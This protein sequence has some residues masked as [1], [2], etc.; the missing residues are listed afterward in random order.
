M[1]KKARILDKL[2]ARLHTTSVRVEESPTSVRRGAG[3]DPAVNKKSTTDEKSVESKA[4]E[5]EAS[6][7]KKPDAVATR[8]ADVQAHR[9][10]SPKEEAS[11][12]MKDGFQELGSLLRGMQSRID[13][14]GEQI[15]R[16]M[17]S[18][19]QLPQ[20]GQQ[21][22]ETLRRLADRFDRQSEQNAVIARSLGDLP[23]MMETV[24]G[25]L[26]RAAAT[27]DRTTKTLEDFRSNMTRIQGSMERMVEHSGKQAQSVQTLATEPQERLTEA[28]QEASKQ[29]RHATD[30]A[31][32][33][34]GAAHERGVKAINRAQ[35]EQAERLTTIAESGQKQSKVVIGLLAGVLVAL[36]VVA[37]LLAA[38]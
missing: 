15:A 17:E 9:R 28:V 2:K 36:C 12:A 11:L 5:K 33:R 30:D 18:V 23:Q 6:A 25:A 14:Q 10:L 38:G 1:V 7:P 26:D 31:A 35:Q 16:T 19:N 32:A 37:G 21:Q 22:L 3:A 13:N 27:D 20:I 24:Q 29:Q 4:S 34:L 8:A